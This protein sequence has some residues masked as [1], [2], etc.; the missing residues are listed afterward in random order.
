MQGGS[1]IGHQ[2]P[3]VLLSDI[4]PLCF[5]PASVYRAAYGQSRVEL[6]AGDSDGPKVAMGVV[7]GVAVAYLM[8]EGLQSLGAYPQALGLESGNPLFSCRK[9]K[10]AAQGLESGNPVFSRLALS[11]S[12]E[13]E[14]CAA[15]RIVI[16]V[17]VS[18]ARAQ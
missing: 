17:S 1:S 5:Q 14:K 9:E 8:F 4:A 3:T 12:G 10:C 15:V 13:K 11:T 6:M 2:T 18:S 7:I 16:W